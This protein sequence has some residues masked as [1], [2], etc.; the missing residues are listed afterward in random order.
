MYALVRVAPGDP[1]GCAAADLLSSPDTAPYFEVKGVLLQVIDGYKLWDIATTPGAPADPKAWPA[2]IQA[3]IDAAHE[4]N[5]R[6]VFMEDAAPRNVVVDAQTQKPFIIDLAQCHFR[7]KMVEG[8]RERPW[9]Q[10]KGWD[11]D[12]EYWE[13][14]QQ[15]NN[16]A[17]V[18]VVMKPRLLLQKGMELDLNFPDHEKLTRDIKREKGLEEQDVA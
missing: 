8:W 13:W 6:G 5:K 1:S 3:A 9:S 11:P 14:M 12:V 4:I 7:D 16:P 10:D 15:R 2:I 18:G 17:A